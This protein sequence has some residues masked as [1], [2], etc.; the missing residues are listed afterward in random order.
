VEALERVDVGH[1]PRQQVALAVAAEAGGRQRL[2]PLVD[3]RPDA[4]EHPERE[5]VRGEPLEVARE[6]ARQ[7]EEA[8]G[9]DR[10]CQREDRGPLGRA[11]DEV[12]GGRHQTD[13]EEDGERT[14]GDCERD[15][16]PGRT[17]EREQA[18]QSPDHAASL[19]A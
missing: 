15:P 1:H 2:E 8:D 14:E 5:V 9:D 12:A 3:A 17:R 19:S 6:R 16:R 7:A 18:T 13:P 4:T 10:G 11:R